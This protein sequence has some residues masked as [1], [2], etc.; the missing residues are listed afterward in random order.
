MPLIATSRPVRF[1]ALIVA[2]ILAGPLEGQGPAKKK[3]VQAKAY[4]V[5]KETATEGE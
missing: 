5:P 3:W 2:A 4:V 1:V